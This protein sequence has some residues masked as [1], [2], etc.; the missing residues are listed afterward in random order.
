M[1]PLWEGL[2]AFS[3]LGRAF[4]LAGLVSMVLVQG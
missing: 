4:M 1:L 2:H 3:A